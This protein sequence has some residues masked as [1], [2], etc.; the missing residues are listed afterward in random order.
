MTSTTETAATI[1]FALARSTPDGETYA[2]GIAPDGTLTHITANLA[3]D[4]VEDILEGRANIADF[5]Y[6]EPSEGQVEAWERDGWETGPRLVELE[7]RMIVYVTHP[8]GSPALWMETASDG[9]RTLIDDGKTPVVLALGEDVDEAV[10]AWRAA[11]GDD[12]AG[13]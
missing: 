4:D 11:V 2:A 5:E 10:A 12:E 7:T 6:D 13:R 8:D 1:R 9:T 3:S